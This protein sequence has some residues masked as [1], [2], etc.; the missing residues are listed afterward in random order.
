[1]NTMS[2][3]MPIHIATIKHFRFLDL[4]GEIRNRIYIILLC[5]FDLPEKLPHIPRG[6]QHLQPRIE[7]QILGTCRKIYTEANYLKLRTN[8]YIQVIL[9]VSF[10]ELSPLIAGR[11]HV[12]PLKEKAARKFKGLV[13]SHEITAPSSYQTQQSTFVFRHRDLNI[14]CEALAQGMWYIR[15]HQKRISHVVTLHNPFDRNLGDE[16]TSSP[17]P[18]L[19]E[20]LVAP[21]RA[22]LSGFRRF[23]FKG[24]INQDIRKAAISDITRPLDKNPDAIL[25][26]LEAHKSRGDQH[27]KDKE[28]YR[29]IKLW[30]KALR[31]IKV[32]AGMDDTANGI[33]DFGGQTFINRLAELTFVLFSNKIH[34]Y[35]NIMW[36]RD[37]DEEVRDHISDGLFLALREA[38]GAIKMFESTTWVTWQPSNRQMGDIFYRSARAFALVGSFEEAVGAIE[39]ANLM[40][41]GDPVIE[42]EKDTLLLF[43]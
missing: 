17:C 29:A 16:S 19:Q 7:P 43:I 25:R 27:F 5:T 22:H 23:Q 42:A 31:K 10:R 8:L 20:M 24:E 33:F 6:L 38:M 3:S 40:L 2:V 18:E 35:L 15:G 1:M 36:E 12:L 26:Q 4:P 30:E 39:R 28:E 21:Y 37:R 14:F 11:L 34:A 9:K 13:M 41:P 32:L